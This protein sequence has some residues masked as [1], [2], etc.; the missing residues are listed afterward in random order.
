MSTTVY[1]PL[2]ARNERGLAHWRSMA[3]R[4]A[5]GLCVSLVGLALLGGGLPARSMGQGAFSSTAA[6]HA[7]ERELDSVESSLRDGRETLQRTTERIAGLEAAQQDHNQRLRLL[8]ERVRR[9]QRGLHVRL[10]RLYYLNQRNKA[11]DFLS[12]ARN[13]S[14]ARDQHYL[15]LLQRAGLESLLHAHN[16]LE[17]LRNAFQLGRVAGEELETLQAKLEKDLLALAERQTQLRLAL[18]RERTASSPSALLRKGGPSGSRDASASL[19]PGQDPAATL[20]STLLTPAVRGRITVPFGVT[21]SRY[22]LRKFQRGIVVRTPPGELARAVATGLV[23]HAGNFRG[24]QQLVLL[25]H[26]QGFFSVY[27]HLRGLRVQV[28]RRVQ[29]GETLGEIRGQPVAGGQ[30]YELYFELRWRDAPQDPLPWFTP[31]SRKDW[32]LRNSKRASWISASLL[33][34]TEMTPPGKALRKP[35]APAVLLGPA[36]MNPN[37]APP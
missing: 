35:S 31:Q 30:D 11:A 23:V 7:L 8:Q 34:S 36:I 28:G 5:R 27:G 22:R 17:A 10:S 1:D 20:R 24:Y 13:R 26:G 29:T 37:A 25:Q 15:G 21:D 2:L 3:A 16:A 14:F 6:L 4:L 9:T 19:L 18:Q 32:S 12:L 33:G